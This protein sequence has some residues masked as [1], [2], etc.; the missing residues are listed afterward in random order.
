MV[1]LAADIVVLHFKQ[2]LVN[3]KAASSTLLA[4]VDS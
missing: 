3:M 1:A 2:D 4:L